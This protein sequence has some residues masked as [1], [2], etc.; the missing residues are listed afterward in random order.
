MT[1]RATR[2]GRRTAAGAAIVAA[3]LLVTSTVSA[4]LSVLPGPG[5]PRTDGQGGSGPVC[6]IATPFPQF[7]R[8]MA[9]VSLCSYTP[10]TFPSAGAITVV[11]V[12][13]A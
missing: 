5:A 8:C 2:R 12:V 1:G 6:H 4:G 7:H 9:L 3:L 13:T 11:P 10:V